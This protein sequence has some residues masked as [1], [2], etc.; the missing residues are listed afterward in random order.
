MKMK[1]KYLTPALSVYLFKAEMCFLQTSVE[2]YNNPFNEEE[3]W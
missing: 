3:Q 1:N 2:D